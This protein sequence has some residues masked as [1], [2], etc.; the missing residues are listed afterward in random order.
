MINLFNVLIIWLVDSLA[1]LGTAYILPGTVVSNF[2]TALLTSVVL[3]LVNA[4][5]R[6]IFIFLTL[7]LNILTFGLFTLVINA[8]M[9]MLVSAIVPGFKVRDFWAAFIFAIILS[10]INGIFFYIL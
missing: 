3:G 4:F 7:P 10:I 1:I 8:L 2:G 6:P 5:I 9:V